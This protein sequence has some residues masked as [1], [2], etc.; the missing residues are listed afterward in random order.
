M[1]KLMMIATI[2]VAGLMFMPSVFAYN[3]GYGTVSDV[4]QDDSKI[5]G[6]S[7][8]ITKGSTDDI[9]I[10]KYSGYDLKILDE[11]EHATAGNRPPGYAWVGV[12][13]NYPAEV[14][15]GD[16]DIYFNGEKY[17]EG[18]GEKNVDNFTDYFGIKDTNLRNA[19]QNGTLL[20]YTILI[21]LF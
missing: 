19:I 17:P 20:E 6:S 12:K 15:E 8:E 13:V 3:G 10:V 16:Y 14:H 11:E 4:T 2:L 5:E 7:P 1:K 9:T 21:R 18:E